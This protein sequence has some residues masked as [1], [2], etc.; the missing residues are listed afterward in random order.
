MKKVLFIAL[1]L[2]TVACSSCS[3]KDDLATPTD[4]SGTS[5]KTNNLGTIAY[6][7]YLMLKFPS[8]TS[9]E[10]WSKFESGTIFTQYHAGVYS[11]NGNQITINFGDGPTTGTIKGETITIAENGTLTADFIKQ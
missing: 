5:W 1:V 4:L 6:P 10:E 3:K 2:T 11:L 8:K 9:A 7:E